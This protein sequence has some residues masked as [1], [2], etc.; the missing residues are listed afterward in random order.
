MF[1]LNGSS[2]V[3]FSLDTNLICQGHYVDSTVFMR[4]Y[5]FTTMV[6]GQDIRQP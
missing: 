5:N 3:M 4:Y 6:F 2:W 1:S